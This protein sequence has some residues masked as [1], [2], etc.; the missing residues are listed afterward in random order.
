MLSLLARTCENTPCAV[1]L[2]KGTSTRERERLEGSVVRERVHARLQAR[3]RPD[4]CRSFVLPVRTHDHA[5]VF[6]YHHDTC[7]EGQRYT[8]RAFLDDDEGSR[9][10]GSERRHARTRPADVLSQYSLSLS[11]FLS[12]APFFP[13]SI[14][15]Q[16][17]YAAT[18]P[19]FSHGLEE[20]VIWRFWFAI[21]IG[22]CILTNFIKIILR[23]VSEES[24]I[25]I[26][27]LLRFSDLY[28]RIFFTFY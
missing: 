11:P 8:K 3:T 23:S 5:Y 16:L 9:T 7:N 21:I 2:E 27:K 12:R 22:E 19:P 28:L 1:L 17:L 24:N 15:F 14:V 26:S 25:I 6:V 18:K 13:S 20:T 10:D 4:C